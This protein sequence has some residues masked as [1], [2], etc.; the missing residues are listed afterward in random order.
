M[1]EMAKNSPHL[2]IE[3]MRIT[4][5]LQ[6]NE[7][8]LLAIQTFSEV[9]KEDKIKPEKKS[10]KKKQPVNNEEQSNVEKD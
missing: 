6:V 8:N 2:Q 4:T 5:E 3:Y 1:Q 7:D 9:P 10:S